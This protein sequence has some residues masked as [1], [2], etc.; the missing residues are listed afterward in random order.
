MAIVP[1]QLPGSPPTTPAV[2]QHLAKVWVIPAILGLS[3]DNFWLA[4]M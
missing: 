1:S 3:L 4:F 2:I